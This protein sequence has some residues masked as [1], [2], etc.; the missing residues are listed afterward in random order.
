MPNIAMELAKNR[1]SVRNHSPSPHGGSSIPL[2]SLLSGDSAIVKS[3]PETRQAAL[4][5]SAR[6]RVSSLLSS[7]NSIEQER[8]TAPKIILPTQK[9]AT[10][11]TTEPDTPGFLFART[12]SPV[13]GLLKLSNSSLNRSQSALG[14]ST[15]P[16]PAPVAVKTASL[17][18]ANSK[19][20]TKKPASKRN[21]EST[22]KAKTDA[23]NKKNTPSSDAK[24]QKAAPARR[25][26]KAKESKTKANEKE[27]KPNNIII[28][29]MQ[30][31]N[32]TPEASKDNTSPEQ[33]NTAKA[34]STQKEEKPLEPKKETKPNESKKD[35][36]SAGPKKALKSNEPKKEPKVS[37]VKKEVDAKGPPKDIKSKDSKSNA[38]DETKKEAKPSKRSSTATKKKDPTP[39]PQKKSNDAKASQ[40]TP[41]VLLPPPPLK[42]PSVLDAL[43][44]GKNPDNQEEPV[45][46]ID[47]PLYSV[48]SNSY[49]DE[50]GQ[51]VFNFCK[52]V[53]DKFGQSSKAKRNLASELQG[54]EEED[55]DAIEV[56]DDDGVEEDDDDE[57]D[58]DDKAPPSAAS[59]AS[60]KKK[61]HPMK[62]RSLIGKYD[63]EDPF[64]DDSELLWEEQRVA[65]KDGFFVYFGPLIEKGQYAS[66]E[67]VNGTMKR[68]GI[69]Y[70]K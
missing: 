39:Q 19:S 31:L 14:P 55:E 43:D 64:I 6:V 36:K 24:L 65:T 12:S 51:V 70:S 25:S 45:I 34:G 49:M 59:V 17:P 23:D 8:I 1:T 47:V 20:T 42:S 2:L 57:M 7:D 3:D 54:G 37:E 48:E 53:H 21:T 35:V 41:K 13:T 44:K 18:V 67:R 56:E 61:S 4:L 63:I 40:N 10:N 26:N 9:V 15:P 38:K 11:T 68:G 60:P 46:L 27:A 28:E 58:L 5:N 66:F 22:K 50:N 52:L 29:D 32:T 69:K 16:K 30:K 62:G 33:E